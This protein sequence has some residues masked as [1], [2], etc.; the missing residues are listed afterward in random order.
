MMF[1]MF[2]W[3]LLQLVPSS[4]VAASNNLPRLEKSMLKTLVKKLRATAPQ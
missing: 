2:S 4:V 1:I 3:S